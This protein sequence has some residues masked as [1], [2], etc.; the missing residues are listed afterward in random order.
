MPGPH[1]L[2]EGLAFAQLAADH[3]QLVAHLPSF[4]CSVGDR[5]GKVHSCYERWKGQRVAP[6][7]SSVA[8]PTTGRPAMA[9]SRRW[10]P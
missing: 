1:Q 6:C 4:A 9:A 2:G 8:T 10:A 3:Q 5:A 7:G